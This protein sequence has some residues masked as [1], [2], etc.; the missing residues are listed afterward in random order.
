MGRFE[1]SFPSGNSFQLLPPASRP[2]GKQTFIIRTALYFLL[3]LDYSDILPF[4]KKMIK[5]MPFSIIF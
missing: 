2:R 1:F 5:A 3:F 4:L